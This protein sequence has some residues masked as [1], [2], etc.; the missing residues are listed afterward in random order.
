MYIWKIKHDLTSNDLVIQFTD[1]VRLSSMAKIPLETLSLKIHLTVSLDPESRFKNC[2][3][4]NIRSVSK[5][6]SL[7]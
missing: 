6:D 4:V 2:I 3:T 5:I 7:K 1:S